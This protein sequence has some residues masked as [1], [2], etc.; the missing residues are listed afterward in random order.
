MIFNRWS[1]LVC[2]ILSVASY[3]WAADYVLHP[4]TPTFDRATLTAIGIRMPVSG[5]D[6][7]NAR[8]DVRYKPTGTGIWYSSLSLY[9]VRPETI[10]TSIVP[11]SSSFAG[12]V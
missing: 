11:A 6:N 2:G 12:S 10:L 5:D 9:R 7:Y 1:S 4:G 3:S 8:V